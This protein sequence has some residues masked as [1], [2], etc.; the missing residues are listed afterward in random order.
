MRR[1]NGGKMK[2]GSEEKAVL[3]EKTEPSEKS[4]FFHKLMR[5]VLPIALQQFLLACVS[6]ADALMLGYLDQDAMSAVSLAG[7]VTFVFNLFVTALTIGGF[8]PV[9]GDSHE[10]FYG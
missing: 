7:Q 4:E 1:G 9:S 8:V 10:I 5:L 6:A 2:T 3:S